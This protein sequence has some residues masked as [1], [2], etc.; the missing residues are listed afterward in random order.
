MFECNR[1][2]SITYCYISRCS[3]ENNQNK[4][5][6]FSIHAVLRVL[7]QLS[8]SSRSDWSRTMVY[9]SIHHGNDVTCHVLPFVLLFRK[10]ISVIVKSK[11]TTIFR[12]LH[13]YTHHRNDAIKCSK[14]W[15]ETTRLWL[16]VPL[17]FWT[18]YDVTSMVYKSVE[19]GKLWSIC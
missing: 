7:Q 5:T 1:S 2:C 16:V 13:S 6:D 19:Y 9:E 15:S 14:L 12:G 4:P 8:E 10:K 17:E 11:S 18:F 3:A